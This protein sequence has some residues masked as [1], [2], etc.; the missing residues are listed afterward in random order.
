MYQR[1][2]KSLLLPEDFKLP[3]HHLATLIIRISTFL[4][5]IIILLR[6]DLCRHQ[7]QR[8]NK[9]TTTQ[10]TS[11]PGGFGPIGDSQKSLPQM[12]TS[13][14][15]HSIQPDEDL[16]NLKPVVAIRSGRVVSLIRPLI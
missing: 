16:N 12:P 2:L 15:R 13:N 9:V 6:K 7:Q 10:R 11:T 4:P 14:V 3:D 8:N 1:R 5:D